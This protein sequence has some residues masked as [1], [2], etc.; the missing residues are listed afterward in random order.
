VSFLQRFGN[1]VSGVFRGPN[2][3]WD[4]G[5]IIGFKAGV[6]Y[7]F[8]YVYALISKG[9]VPDPSAFGLGYAAVLAGIGGLIA[10]K[11]IG[12]AKANATP[13]APAP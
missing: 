5:R 10:A 6:A 4:L 8:V 13:P 12:V 1:V 3:N 2:G 7:P 11:D 9:S